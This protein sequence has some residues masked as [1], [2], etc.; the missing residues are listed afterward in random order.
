MQ[1]L[2][3][4]GISS[5]FIY[6]FK[7]KITRLIIIYR[8][9]HLSSKLLSLD[10]LFIVFINWFWKTG[11][12][13]RTFSCEWAKRGSFEVFFSYWYS[14]KSNQLITSIRPSSSIAFQT[15]LSSSHNIIFEFLDVSLT[16]NV[17]KKIII[18]WQKQHKNSEHHFSKCTLYFK[19][20][21][22]KNKHQ[23]FTILAWQCSLSLVILPIWCFKQGRRQTAWTWRSEMISC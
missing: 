20:K 16:W 2:L 22:K 9:R 23:V 21:Y 10:N 8:T 17:Q 6:F 12:Y 4:I 7:I 11:E 15:V 14:H 3:F 5:L 19:Q 13:W 18:E 1:K